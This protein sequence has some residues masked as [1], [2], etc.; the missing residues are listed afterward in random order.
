MSQVDLT[1]SINKKPLKIQNAYT[2]TYFSRFKDR[3]F[4]KEV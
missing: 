4:M 2:F 1:C 3:L